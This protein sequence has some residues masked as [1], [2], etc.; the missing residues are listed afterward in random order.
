MTFGADDNCAVGVGEVRS[1]NHDFS[2]DV[3]QAQQQFSEKVVTPYRAGFQ[4]E[5]SCLSIVEAG[6]PV[7]FFLPATV[8]GSAVTAAR[9]GTSEA[10]PM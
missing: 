5:K 3:A 4:G 10:V 1:A 9:R 8:T 2:L 7:P 6:H